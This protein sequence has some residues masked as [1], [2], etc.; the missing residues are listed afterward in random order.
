MTSG[1]ATWPR[2][3]LYF[4]SART[5][6]VSDPRCNAHDHPYELSAG[7]GGVLLRVVQR[8]QGTDVA[9]PEPL[10]VEEHGRSHERPCQR[11]TAGLIGAR[12]EPGPQR[13]VEAEKP[14]ACAAHARPVRGIRSGW[15]AS[16]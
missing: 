15:A 10:E 11:A 1:A 3:G 8:S 16:R 6:R 4:P 5:V 2:P 7:L 14:P 12:D 9:G 13:S